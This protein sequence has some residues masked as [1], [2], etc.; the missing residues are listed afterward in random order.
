MTPE[1]LVPVWGLVILDPR[2]L[3]A[4]SIMSQKSYKMENRG[5]TN[6]DGQHITMLQVTWPVK[7]IKPPGE[8][9]AQ[10]GGDKPVVTSYPAWYQF[11]CIAT[12]LEGDSCDRLK[13]T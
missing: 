8:S 12:S 10:K 2:W 7:S 4:C 6:D 5:Y 9:E 13:Q 1:S 3:K 11:K